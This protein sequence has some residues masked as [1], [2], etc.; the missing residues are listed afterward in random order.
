MEPNARSAF[1]S[2]FRC[3]CVYGGEGIK[4]F[5][6]QIQN[7]TEMWNLEMGEVKEDPGLALEKFVVTDRRKKKK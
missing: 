3:V 5:R 4:T 2:G 6:P 7:T 1:K